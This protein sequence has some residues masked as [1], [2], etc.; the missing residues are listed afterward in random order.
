MY[1][2][3][4]ERPDTQTE[5]VSTPRGIL[6]RRGTWFRATEDSIE[7]F[8]GDL[9]EREPL[10]ILI[11]R[12][13]RWLIAHKN[14]TLWIFVIVLVLLKPYWV[15]G[16]V[17][18]ATFVLARLVAPSLG[19]HF[20][21][22]VLKVMEFVPVQFLLYLG[23]LS[24]VAAGGDVTRLAVGLVGF[25]VLRWNVI[26]LVLRRPLGQIHDSLYSL[27]R[28]DQMLRA[29]IIKSAMRNRIPLPGLQEIERSVLR[30]L[31]RRDQD[32]N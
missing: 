4:S 2:S 3:M 30:A 17:A 29:V 32:G 15:T 20:G 8:A 18:G 12:A 25:M 6:T 24:I 26:D 5:Y 7:E 28:P 1:M 27:P 14:V 10:S 22:R 13:E 11:E 31:G 16:V 9:L 19:G 21:G 23:L